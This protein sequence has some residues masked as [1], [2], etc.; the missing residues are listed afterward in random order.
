[1]P[2]QISVDAKESSP[3]FGEYFDILRKRRRLMAMVGLPIIALGAVLAFALPDVYR[4]EGNIEIE[5]AQASKNLIARNAKDDDPYADQYVQ[6]LST[7]VL[8][9]ANLKRMLDQYKLYDDQAEDPAGAIANLRS[10][11]KV[12]IV[13]ATILDPQTGREREIVTSFDV[14]YENHDPQRAQQ[15]AAWLVNAFMDENRRDR[16]EEASSTAKFFAG[17]AQRMSRHVA[18]LEAKLAEFKSKNVGALPEL[19][20]ANLNA[21]DRTERD[22]QDV[23][24]QMQSLRRERVFLASQYAQARAATPNTGGPTI[25]QLQAEYDRKSAQYDPSHPDM[26]SLRRQIEMLRAGGG[27][28]NS[29]K[30]QLQAQRSI[31]AEVRQRYSADHPDVRRIQRNIDTLQARIAA[32]ETSD[33]PPPEASPV[34]MQLQTQLNATDSQLAALQTRSMELRAKLS[35][36][37][38]RLNTAPEV[39]REYQSVTRDLESA[40]AKYQE[41]LKR[42]MDAEVD[43]A[44]ISGGTADKFTV[45]SSPGIPRE[46]A[47]PARL[48]LFVVSVVAAAVIALTAVFVAQMLD[49]TVRGVRD[50][51]DILEVMPLTTVPV[52]RRGPSRP[53]ALLTR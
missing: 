47:K 5:G 37:E 2:Q 3:E 41:L 25:G 49:Q 29:L 43:E 8:S 26:V 20:G 13:T 24:S 21:V 16:E 51:R 40:R 18:G 48:L 32:G 17:E 9:D 22:I 27:A 50:I 36:L 1:M 38:S 45:K 10:D 6:S 34:A 46:P 15:G 28:G 14:G 33:A 23:E 39:E 42:Q 53:G 52:I 7:E 44:A 35:D 19:N 12:N 31:L 30:A 4:S 11:I